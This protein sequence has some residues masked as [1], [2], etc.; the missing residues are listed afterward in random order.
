VTSVVL[1]VDTAGP[2]IGAA[3]V[4]APGGPRTWSAR[5]VRGA[6]QLL[7]PALAELL[8]GVE[9]LDRV[10]VSTG[11]G[12]FTSLRVGVAAALGIAV[13]RGCEVV[14]VSSLAARAA[15]LEGEPRV[16]ALLDARKGKAYA[17][18]WVEGCREGPEADL[19]PAE[20]VGLAE[21]PFLATGEGAVVFREV[22]EA[23]GGTVAEQ[24]DASPALAVARLGL[25]G[26]PQPPGTVRLRYL[27][28]A[29]ARLP[30]G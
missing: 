25:L 21:V 11:P 7:A 23:A 19:P 12:A 6:D 17:G 29:D 4:G 22:V 1:G 13:A 3:L 2:V 30:V 16:L 9:V 8:D 15:H 14:A 18:F 10:A 20:A 24:A 28:E 5:V 27:R 26:Q